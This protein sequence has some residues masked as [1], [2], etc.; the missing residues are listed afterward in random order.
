VLNELNDG[1]Y[2]E[3]SKQKYKD[4]IDEWLENR[5]SNVSKNTHETYR[6][7]ID[8]HIKPKLGRFQLDKLNSLAIDNFYTELDK[9][10]K[11]SATIKKVHSIIRA[12]LEYALQYQLIKR[13][14][15]SVVKP[16][17]VKHKD[18]IVWDES[19]V[20]Q[21]LDFVK[22]EWDYVLYHL[23]LYTG[24]RKG[25]ILGLKWGDIDFINNKIRVMRSYSRTGFSEGKTKNTRRVIDIDESD[26]EFLIKRK[27]E[28]SK[29]KLKMGPDYNDLDLIICRPTGDPVDVRNVNRRFDK[30]VERSG[31]PRIRFHDMRHTH[32]TL[33]LKMGVPVKV[34]SERLGHGSIELTLNTYTHLLPSMQF[35][36]VQTFNKNMEKIRNI[37]S[38]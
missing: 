38:I 20:I 2:I 14:P 35:E 15:A 7:I 9:Q 11:S 21:F 8:A 34:V 17:A 6:Y 19:E 37:Y 25:E 13:N 5:K 18:I 10:G 16:P 32:A 24:M 3:P 33:M 22:D 23:A 26:T 12:S 36:A 27:K 1:T 31:L 30:F 29:N 4:F 28:I